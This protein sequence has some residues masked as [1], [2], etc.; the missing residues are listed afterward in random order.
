MSTVSRG[1][2][3]G[4]HAL[5]FGLERSPMVS[6]SEFSYVFIEFSSSLGPRE[7][8]SSRRQCRIGPWLVGLPQGQVLSIRDHQI[9]LLLLR[10]AT[11]SKLH[12]L[13]HKLR[14]C[15]RSIGAL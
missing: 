13:C 5:R 15:S 3:R 1:A 4:V 7:V 10:S 8:K 11:G 12:Q 2:E 6:F 14:S 9:H